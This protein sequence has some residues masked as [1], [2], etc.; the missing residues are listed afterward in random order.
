MRQSMQAV[1]AAR[2]IPVV[3]IEDVADATPLAETLTAAGLAV[4]EITLRSASALEAMAVMSRHPD[5]VVGAGTVLTL[6]QVQQ[7]LAAGARFVVAPGFSPGVVQYCRDLQV[8]VLPGVATPTDIQRA[9]E[10]GVDLLKFFPA[11]ALG[12]VRMI[13]ALAA[14]FPQ[15]RFVP[16]GGITADNLADYLG[17]PAVAACGGSWMVDPEL[18]RRRRFDRIHAQIAAALQVAAAAEKAYD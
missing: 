6:G 8:P 14:P 9:L 3:T 16:T 10:H 2:V 5:L 7:A 15:V 13:R 4:V 18:V 17:L 12:G 11:E 1:C